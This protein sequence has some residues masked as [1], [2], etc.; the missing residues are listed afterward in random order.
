MARPGQICSLKATQSGV[1]FDVLAYT[2]QMISAFLLSQILI[3]VAFLFD[4]ASFQFKKRE[5]SLVCF[6]IAASF[7]ATHFYILGALSAAAVVA[8]SATRFTVSIFT[9]DYRLKY[10]FLTLIILAGI[11]TYEVPYDL[12]IIFAGCLVT[13][14]VF[15]PNE[16]LMR[17]LMAPASMSAII[18]NV[19]IFSPAGVLLETFFL[20]SNLLSYWRF[21]I[22]KQPETKD[23]AGEA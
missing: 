18:F 23:L 15:Q 13:F 9:T 21:Y 1:A 19:I 14:A 12:L 4:L 3:G 7:I 20:G 2:Y 16:K 17:Q 5:V 6:A 22:K 10:V 11:A 8:L